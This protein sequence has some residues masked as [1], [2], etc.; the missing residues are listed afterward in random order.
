[1]RF[2]TEHNTG[3]EFLEVDKT[4][5]V[6]LKSKRLSWLPQEYINIKKLLVEK[7]S[8]KSD[9]LNDEL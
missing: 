8:T 3:V 7:R 9:A 6:S 4:Q 2:V 1:M 5:D